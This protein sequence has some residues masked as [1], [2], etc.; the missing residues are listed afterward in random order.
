MNISK[1]DTLT[2]ILETSIHTMLWKINVLMYQCTNVLVFPYWGGANDSHF[3]TIGLWP[4]AKKSKCCLRLNHCPSLIGRSTRFG[5]MGLCDP[6]Y[7]S[8]ATFV[9]LS[10]AQQKSTIKCSKRIWFPLVTST[11]FNVMFRVKAW[12]GGS[13]VVFESS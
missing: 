8:I 11:I 6:H 12:L 13:K 4:W 5:L 10:C 2:Y 3:F 9:W 1:L 7:N